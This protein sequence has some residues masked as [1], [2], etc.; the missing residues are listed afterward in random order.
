MT[1]ARHGDTDLRYVFAFT[2]SRPEVADFYRDVLGI[3]IEEAKEDAVWFSTNG[4][5]FSLHDDDDRQTAKE[6]RESHA[7]VMGIGVEDLDAA[8]ERARSA[9][10]VV[11]RFES[12]FFVRD[13]DGRYV[14]VSAKREAR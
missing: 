13:P 2:A 11:E 1:G 5:R 9:S 7:F 8:Y 14:I 3:T 6:V 12:W 10:A 4:A